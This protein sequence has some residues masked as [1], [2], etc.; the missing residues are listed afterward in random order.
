VRGKVAPQFGS[1]LEE[2]FHKT[3]HF[4]MKMLRN[5]SSHRLL[6]PEVSAREIAYFFMLAMRALVQSDLS[7][8]ARYERVLSTLFINLSDL[9][10]TRLMNSALAFHLESSYEQLKV[11][12]KDVLRLAKESSDG[13]KAPNNL[14]R[15]I[16]NYFLGIFRELGEVL[17]WLE[18]VE[19]VEPAVLAFHRQRIKEVSLRLFYQSFWHGLFPMEIQT[20]FYADL[21]R[22][23]FYI[24]PFQHSFINFIG[25]AIFEE[26]FKETES[27]A[28]LRSIEKSKAS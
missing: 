2:Q 8:I 4:Q 3:A 10:L 28:M 24:E 14:N 15:R 23:K 5:W 18:Q 11:L 21:Q 27:P 6:S 19:Q 26:C 13:R 25:Q 20:T 17:N 1:W 9:E 12:H 22:V 16:D 7:E